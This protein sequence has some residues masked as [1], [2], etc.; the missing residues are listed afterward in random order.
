[1]ITY[2]EIYLLVFGLDV[3]CSRKS[4]FFVNRTLIML[5]ATERLLTEG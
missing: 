4:F 3:I 1:M 5:D 2:E